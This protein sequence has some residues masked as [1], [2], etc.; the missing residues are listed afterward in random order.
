LKSLALSTRN[1][2]IKNQR[3]SPE[4]GPIGRALVQAA[5]PTPL[6]LPAPSRARR[7]PP[8]GVRAPVSLPLSVTPCCLSG[9]TRSENRARTVVASNGV[10][11]VAF[12][13][14]GAKGRA[15]LTVGVRT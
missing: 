13:Y 12:G 5:T 10:G 6:R 11:G 8:G 2:L 4:A 9:L 15:G 3:T 14:P 7:D 1:R